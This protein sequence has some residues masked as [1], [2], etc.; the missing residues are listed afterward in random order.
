MNERT[1]SQILDDAARDRTPAGLD[2][3]PQ[4]IARIQKGT[5][6]IMKPQMKVLTA[7]LLVLLMF[8]VLFFTVPGV[9]AAI[10]RWFGYVPGVGL[11]REGQ[12]RVLAAPVSQTRDSVSVTVKQVLLDSDRTVLT[13]SVEGIPAD[14][15]S[16]GP[17]LRC[18]S[19]ASLRLPDGTM[20]PGRA[21]DGDM[22]DT[23]Y[24]D[25]VEYPV[26]PSKVNDVDLV[27]SC[28]FRVKPGMAPEN[29]RVPLHFIPAPPDMTAFPVI[30]I[31]TPTLPAPTK[32]APETATSETSNI[33]LTLDR[34]IQMDD[35]YLIY[36]TLHWQGDGLN[37]IDVVD[38][39]TTIHLLGLD[40]KNL[41]YENVDDENTGMQYDQKKVV[42]SLTTPPVEAEGP[43][44]VV[45]DAV[46]ASLPAGGSFVF[47]LGPNPEFGKAVELNKD[48]K[49]G[50]YSVRVVSVTPSQNG[51]SFE[52]VSDTGVLDAYTIDLEHPV[53]GGG[54]GGGGMSGV[55]SSGFNYVADKLPEGSV[56]ITISG[57]DVIRK[58]PWQAKWTPPAASVKP[59]PTRTGVC[60]NASS[61][62]KA[63]KQ[64]PQ[65]PDG[66]T[67]KV[68]VFGPTEPGSGEWQ[69]FLSNLD[70]SDRKILPGVRTPSISPDGSKLAK[71]L[72]DG[73][74]IVDL[75][76][77]QK[78]HLDGTVEFD[79]GPLWT[80]DGSQIVFMRG[81]GS[82]DLFIVNVDGT[83]L[84]R[85]TNGGVQ[86]WPVGW[87][88]DGQHL[89]Y[90][91]PGPDDTFT[92]YSLDVTTGESQK[93]PVN[94]ITSISPDGK[95]IITQKNAFGGRSL[96]YISGLDG[97][98]PTLLADSDI[99]ALVPVWSP[100]GQW[101]IMSVSDIDTEHLI[102]TLV[103]PD[104]CTIIPLT[105]FNGEF[106]VWA[107]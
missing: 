18:P 43:L 34:A 93:F 94:D 27:I 19:D 98:N 41:P 100:D 26:I 96:T 85:L 23:G 107:P 32:A 15:I 75:A 25:R 84:R 62:K 10:Q 82:Y 68:L 30:E 102:P 2:L 77:D 90:S 56:T 31:S 20:L 45:V 80:L 61:W 95:T 60:L 3:T 22:W 13:Y 1:Y 64:K 54:G 9:A 55:F 73:I 11:V 91:V 104:D 8:V 79:F 14:A 99:W 89:L 21:L 67:G 105:Y 97:S 52:M 7:V 72:D 50:G 88:S 51:Y 16:T 48:V 5:G 101:L 66:P 44:T 46:S 12:I 33:S 36:A 83:G 70:G 106:M 65:L 17:E 40:G 58:G 4:I 6:R 76:T 29:W 57:I 103:R 42:F 81:N 37:S 59:A 71:D 87:M 38:A 35:G 74:Y 28:L 69:Y 49:V 53:A 24:A 86:E 47:D 39:Y 63:L 92:V 78:N